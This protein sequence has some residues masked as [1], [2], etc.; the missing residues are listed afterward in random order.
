MGLL[1]GI[2]G[3][4]WI[5]RGSIRDFPWSIDGALRPILEPPGSLVDHCRVGLGP[6][7]ELLWF[8]VGPAGILDGSLGPSLET[9]LDPEGAYLGLDPNRFMMGPKWI[10]HGTALVFCC[11]IMGFVKACLVPTWNHND[12]LWGQKWILGG[13]FRSLQE[14]TRFV[15]FPLN[16]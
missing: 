8:P 4:F 1:L 15:G 9:I 3:T 13:P 14:P 10:H 2:F 7:L 16:Y 12:S 11:L 5:P 6:I